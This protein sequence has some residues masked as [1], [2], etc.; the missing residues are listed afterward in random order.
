MHEAHKLKCIC[1]TAVEVFHHVVHR[2]Q[3]QTFAMWWGAQ[4]SCIQPGLNSHAIFLSLTHYIKGLYSHQITMWRWLT[5]SRLGSSPSYF[6]QRIEWLVH[7][8]D[9][10]LRIVIFLLQC[11]H[12]LE[13][14]RTSFS[15]TCFNAAGA[16]SARCKVETVVLPWDFGI[17]SFIKSK[18]KNKQKQ[19]SFFTVPIVLV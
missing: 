17:W 16:P 10:W 8:W 6:L 7:Q 2:L 1:R 15:C 12:P 19:S 11:P 5:Y 4:I 9:S 18:H 13:W 14:S 3:K